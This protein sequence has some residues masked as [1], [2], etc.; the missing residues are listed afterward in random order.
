M[1]KLWR[2]DFDSKYTHIKEWLDDY[3]TVT[4]PDGDAAIR[5]ARR[6][7]IGK[8]F[9]DGERAIVCKCITLKVSGLK[10]LGTADA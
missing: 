5:K 1:T 8:T 9:D 10:L 4:A 2:V 7:L 3:I 6:I